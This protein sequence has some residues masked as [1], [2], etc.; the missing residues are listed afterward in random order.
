MVATTA[1]DTLAELAGDLLDR[2]HQ[3]PTDRDGW[4]AL[5]TSCQGVPNVVTALQDQAV[6]EL[7]RRES[8]WDE[9]GTLGEVEH[10]VGTVA[11]DAADLLAPLVGAS[12][13]QAQRRVETAVRICGGREPSEAGDG[14]R[15]AATGLRGLH[16]AMLDGRLDPY[17]ASVVATELAEAP[18]DVAAA[19]VDALDPFLADSDAPALRRRC[20][21]LLARIS[22]DLLRQRAVRARSRCGLRRWV[23]EPGVDTWLGT[24]PSE[25]AAAAWTAVDRLAHSYVGDGTCAT[26]EQARGKALTDLVLQHSSVD[27][28]V[29]LTAPVDGVEG[30]SSTRPATAEGPGRDDDLVQV[31]G[32]RPSEPVLVPRAW[33]REHLDPTSGPLPCHSMSGARLDPE[34]RFASDG[35]RPGARL[36]ALVRA[37]DGRCRFPG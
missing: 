8:V 34:S 2:L 7:A 27:V 19:V 30:A 25:D 22:P 26:V 29:V 12:H 17:R 14:V 31:H 11:L 9:D 21:R 23:A 36:A 28:R 24:F 32:S 5:V 37:R 4:T 18:A 3:A 15:G 16:A 35:Y 6:V 13:G 33:V 20:R 1:A 10:L